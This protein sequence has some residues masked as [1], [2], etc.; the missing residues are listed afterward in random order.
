MYMRKP[1]NIF[2]VVVLISLFSCRGGDEKISRSDIIPD[3]DLVGVLTDIYVADG[4]LT[5]PNVRIRFVEKDSTSNY[6]DVLRAHGYT[7]EQ[8]N[9]TIHHYLLKKPEK[10]EKLHDRVVASLSI[11]ESQLESEIPP[12][13]P[14]KLNLWQGPTTVAVPET[15][16]TNPVPV[17]I[18]ISDT[19]LYVLTFDLIIYDDDQ[20]INP[21]TNL[22]FWRAGE[23]E[24]GVRDYWNNVEL[25]RDGAVH[26]YSLEKN[27]TDLSFTHIKGWLL[28]HNPQQGRWQKH[29][30]V[31]GIQLQHGDAR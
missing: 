15:G 29:M 2:L 1:L 22:F 25:I 18:A 28:D 26:K 30:R 8:F 14:V 27:L 19:G 4:L 23:T 31:T 17:D 13:V 21:R 7:M 12:V 9:R 24:E 20:S 5:I 10:L 3:K 16:I 6:A 11:Q